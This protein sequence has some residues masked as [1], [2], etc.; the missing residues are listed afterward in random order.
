MWLFFPSGV[1]W[2]AV[3]F[4]EDFEAEL[5]EN[6]EARIEVSLLAQSPDRE[7]TEVFINTEMYARVSV[8][9]LF[10]KLANVANRRDELENQDIS[11][12]F[13][14][15]KAFLL[16]LLDS[17][18]EISMPHYDLDLIFIYETEKKSDNC[19]LLRTSMECFLDAYDPNT[20]TTPFGVFSAHSEGSEFECAPTSL[21]EQVIDFLNDV[22]DDLRYSIAKDAAIIKNESLAV[23]DACKD[24]TELPDD[25]TEQ[26]SSQTF[27]DISLDFQKKITLQKLGR[28]PM[29][30]DTDC[31]IGDDEFL[32]LLLEMEK[33]DQ[34][35][36]SVLQSRNQA[37]EQIR[38]SQQQ[39]IL[40]AS[41]L[42]RIPNLAGLVRTCEVFRAA[43]LAIADASI[44]QDKQFQLI[45]SGDEAEKYKEKVIS[46][47]DM[48]LESLLPTGSYTKLY[49]Y[50]HLLNG[51][52][53][54]TASEEAVEIL[55]NARGVRLMREDMKMVKMTTHTPDY[56][57]ISA[58]VW[59]HLGGAERSGDG[60]VIGMID[61]GINPDHPSFA[62]LRP[63]PASNLTR[64]K[65]RCVVG[66]EFPLA[67]CNGKIVGAQHFAPTLPL[68]LP[69]ITELRCSPKAITMDMQAAWPLVLGKRMN[70]I[71]SSETP[72]HIVLKSQHLSFSVETCVLGRIAAYKAV[73]SFGGYMS[74]VV[75]AVDKAVE[76]GV[77]ILS[78]SIGPSAVPPGPAA[79]LDI[80][81]VELLFAAKAGVSVIQA[82]GNG[83]PASSS[84]LSFSPWVTSVAASTTDRKY[85]NSI[86]LGTGQSLP[87]TGL[88]PPTMEKEFFPIA[89]AE[90]VCSRNTSFLVAVQN[91]QHPDPFIPALVRGKLI[92]CTY[93]SEFIY[94]PT[95]MEAIGS[96]IQKIGAA[97]FI[98][99]MDRGYDS[100][101][102][103][104]ST[105]TL[106]VPGIVLSSRQASQALW[107]YYDS[108]TVRG[109]NGG[110]AHFGATG[111]ILDG[112]RAIYTS[113]GP[114]I[115]SYSSRGPDVNNALM[116][117]AD[118][119][120]PNIMAPGSAIWAAWSPRSDNNQNAIGQEFALLSGTSMATPHVAGVTALIKQKH[121]N[122]SPAAITSAMMTTADVTDRSGS[123]MRSQG[124]EV[125]TATPFDYGAGAINAAR[126]IDPGLIL[127]IAFKSYIQFLCAVPGV[128]DESVRRAVGLGCPAARSD[129]CSDLNTPSVTVANLVGSRTVV[130]RVTSVASLEETYQ[131][132]VKEPAGVEVAVR[133]QE[134]TIGPNESRNIK[135][136][137]RAREATN[138]YAFGELVLNGDRKHAVRI[139]L[140]IFV[141]NL[142]QNRYFED[143]AFIGYL[144]Y[145]QY[146]KRPEYI[147][148]IMY[149]HCLFFLELLQNANFR[150]A[151]AHPGSK[152][153]PP[154]FVRYII[155]LGG[156]RATLVSPLGNSWS[157][158]IH[159]YKK[160]MCFREGW[161]EF[162]RAHDLK[163]G[164]F[165]VFR[166]EDDR[167][168]SFQ[169]FD[170][171]ACR[172][173]Y[174]P[175]GVQ[176][177]HMDIRR[178]LNAENAS[179]VDTSQGPTT[180]ADRKQI[181]MMD[182]GRSTERMCSSCSGRKFF[183]AIIKYYNLTK[184]YMNIPASFKESIDM[185]T[186][187]KVILKNEE[188]RSWHGIPASFRAS[189]DIATRHQVILK[190]VEGRSWHV[191]ICNKGN[192]GVHLAQGWQE[193]CADNRLEKG[194]KCIFELV[195]MEDNTMLVR[196]FKQSVKVAKHSV[197]QELP[198]TSRRRL[199]TE[200]VVSYLGR[201]TMEDSLKIFP[202]TFPLEGCDSGSSKRLHDDRQLVPH[203]VPTHKSLQVSVKIADNTQSI[204][205][206]HS[207]I[208]NKGEKLSSNSMHAK[209]EV[210][211]F[212]LIPN[213]FFLIVS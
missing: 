55:S 63:Q 117:T 174:S 125:A 29:S 145:L 111:R 47:H 78:L 144:K 173:D 118:V 150:N 202:E 72:N 213:I 16:E 193:F 41:L 61:T 195:S 134:F 70:S 148:F 49:S 153:I 27:R 81:E 185:M 123:P 120:K 129:W 166:Y 112:R 91:C 212:L 151:M 138:A 74:D 1:G 24:I 59:P 201:A 36:S 157:V 149:P 186:K 2:G 69:E 105:L 35:L 23:A 95:S 163:L 115:A 32:K 143:E 18:M 159:G 156:K 71:L 45:R 22:R 54:R 33:E 19:A 66:D 158:N 48:F 4:D 191:R 53:L 122:W 82:V 104:D 65:G 13:Q 12:S 15:G 121:P 133:P 67:A 25:S 26:V 38:Q 43:G 28:Q 73:Y 209:G 64:F 142:A 17:V 141:S 93:M 207:K 58:G 179:K 211:Y 62:N 184:N 172:K 68:L 102:P 147:K 127:D 199:V 20:S 135:I 155:N 187:D 96:T 50:T 57:G 80:L 46:R 101:P 161:R 175:V 210:S 77:D 190:D 8:A 197:E 160:N 31:V 100:E 3:A 189:N 94:A 114:A 89:A 146:W 198:A 167:T 90:D 180:Q 128:D 196:I 85:N 98:I 87:G 171:S 113:Q 60:I 5:S 9:V 132:A 137:L 200:K 192:S 42:D 103:V 178:C 10:Y 168:F 51:F 194:D 30:T 99:T 164:Y 79:F 107:E 76:D 154:A 206:A 136:M 21:M 14:C 139:P 165:M 119:L 39:F 181:R 40:V 110:V 108:N 56:I 182:E 177:A 162:A 106:S 84:I 169:V 188:G 183:V 176:S 88:S 126:A 7:F 131:V 11:A 83:G 97:G 37:V 92:I 75:A 6:H 130:R 170:T 208:R 116:E 86:I 124:N 205:S 152:R 204:K 34:L 52:A 203:L 140:A 44:L 109:V